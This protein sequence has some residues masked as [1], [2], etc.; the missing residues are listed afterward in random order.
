MELKDRAHEALRDLYSYHD[1]DTRF[2]S[3]LDAVRA[4]VAALEDTLQESLRAALTEPSFVETVSTPD[5]SSPDVGLINPPV[6][7]P[8]SKGKRGKRA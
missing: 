8:K 1:S 4:Y 7:E 5:T 3:R 6:D 2:T